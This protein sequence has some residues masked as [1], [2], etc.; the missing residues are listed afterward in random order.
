MALFCWKHRA[1]KTL[2]TFLC[3]CSLQIGLFTLQQCGQIFHSLSCKTENL[4]T[5]MYMMVSTDREADIH[6]MRLLWLCFCTDRDADINTLML[7]GFFA[8]AVLFHLYVTLFWMGVSVGWL[9]L[10]FACLLLLLLFCCCYLCCC[11]EGCFARQTG[12]NNGRG[13]TDRQRQTDRERQRET[14]RDRERQRETCLLYT[15][16]SP[17]DASKSRMPSSA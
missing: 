11:L 3:L 5:E 2:P 4:D 16:P 13:E 17:R 15:S 1:R 7:L 9:G 10:F 12:L 14:E 6:N 8:A